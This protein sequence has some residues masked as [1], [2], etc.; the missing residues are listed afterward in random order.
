[1]KT[2]MQLAELIEEVKRQSAAKTDLLADTR[3]Q[4]RLV[5]MAEFPNKVAMVTLGSGDPPEL[6]R[7]AISD[8]AHQQIAGW[9]NIPWKYYGRLLEDH[10]DLVIAQVNAL[11]EREPGMRMMRVLDGKVRAFLSNRYRRIDNDLVLAKTLPKL[12]RNDGSLPANRIIGSHLSDDS[13][14]IRVVWTDPELEQQIGLTRDGKP[15]IVRPGF[16]MGNSETG[17]GTFKLRGF[18]HRGYCDNGCI[19]EFGDGADLSYS[20][21]HLG[22]KLAAGDGMEIFSDETKRKDDEALVAQVADVMAALGSKEFVDRMGNTLRSLK[23]GEQI[24]QPSKAIE[25]LGK[26]VGLLERELDNVLENLIQD[27]DYSRWGALNA[28]TKVANRE[29]ISEERSLE[30]QD[31]G[32]QL[33]SMQMNTWNRIALAGVPVKAAA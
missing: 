18:F 5:E 11:F 25:V 32:S 27:G 8:N 20:R 21:T 17:R 24:R 9:L 6:E 28:I 7:Y 22:G 26:E 16:E 33:I 23:S 12:I 4:L 31:L 13:M 19:W 29:E 14:R 15:D 2:G 30:L 10:L 3:S 1:M